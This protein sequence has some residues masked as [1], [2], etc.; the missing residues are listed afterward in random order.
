MRMR[1]AVN[2]VG[3]VWIG[4]TVCAAAVTGTLAPLCAFT[5][6]ALGVRYQ[7]KKRDTLRCERVHAQEIAV[8]TETVRTVKERAKD[9]QDCYAAVK[10]RAPWC[11]TPE[12][13]MELA[14][15]KKDVKFYASSEAV[16]AQL[17]DHRRKLQK[18]REPIELMQDIGIGADLIAAGVFLQPALA[19]ALGIAE[20]IR[21]NKE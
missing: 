10:A 4:S 12:Y 6:L 1:N 9:A 5:V 13:Q 20:A 19:V 17:N 11:M 8:L 7:L 2:A 14:A 16:S 3:W 15:A 18:A 21:E